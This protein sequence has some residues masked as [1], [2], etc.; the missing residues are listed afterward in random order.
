[1]LTTGVDIVEIERIEH[2]LQRWGTRFTQRIFTPA[3]IASCGGHAHELAARFAGK[4]ALSKALGT[5]IWCSDGVW[6]R[7]MEILPDSRGK[8]IV[9]LYG[10]ARQRA[11]DLGLKEFAISLSHSDHYAVAFV[12]AQ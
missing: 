4:E 10:R 3:E 5:G 12:V 1:M 8:P 11:S 6:W 2:I 9:H 7:D